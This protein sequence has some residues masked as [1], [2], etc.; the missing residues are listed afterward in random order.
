MDISQKITS[1]EAQ[2]RV[3]LAAFGREDL[4][5]SHTADRFGIYTRLSG[6]RVWEHTGEFV[7]KLTQPAIR[8]STI[9]AIAIGEG[10]EDG[11]SS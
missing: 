8:A 10:V 4:F 1:E 11:T 6:E 3:W 2:S 5:Q 7:N 9:E